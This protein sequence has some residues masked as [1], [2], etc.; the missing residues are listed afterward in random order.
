M[1]ELQEDSVIDAPIGRCFDLARSVEV[2]LLDNTHLGE[3]T[4]AVAGRTSG[5]VNL[6]DRVTW[7]ARHLGVRQTLTTCI[8]GLKP[9]TYFQDTMLQ[10]AF[11]SMQHDHYF[12]P[13][14][15][16]RT[17]MIDVLRVAA[18]LPPFGRLAELLVL[19]RYMRMLLVERSEVLKRIAESDAW[20]RY[21]PQPAP[22]AD[23]PE[24]QPLPSPRRSPRPAEHRHLA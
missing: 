14:T 19:R 12:R 13:L 17:E 1:F 7:R 20:Q 21:L 11:R 3:P 10:G 5:L 23:A 8:T 22:R 9:P 2:H 15:G 18:P 4:V 6:D 24:D 16:D